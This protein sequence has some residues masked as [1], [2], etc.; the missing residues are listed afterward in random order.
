M[1]LYAQLTKISVTWK[2]TERSSRTCESLSLRFSEQMQ[3]LIQQKEYA[4]QVKE[5]NMKALS[6]PSK[7]QTAI[8]ENKSAVP[9]QK[10]RNSPRQF[11]VQLELKGNLCDLM[12]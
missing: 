11:S 3:K 9:R 1:T 6:I 2:R 4:K 10:V 7:P 8:T 5:Y 12:T